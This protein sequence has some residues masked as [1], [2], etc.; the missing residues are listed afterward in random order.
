MYT[1][2][3]LSVEKLLEQIETSVEDKGK[4]G[5]VGQREALNNIINSQD[6]KSW[7]EGTEIGKTTANN[8][9]NNIKDIDSYISDA[10][11]NSSKNKK[12]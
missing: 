12:R 8:I 7:S 3:L 11:K 2:D 5:A 10:R 9:N 6:F 1:N 4:D